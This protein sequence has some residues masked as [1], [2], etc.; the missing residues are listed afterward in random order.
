[1]ST[2]S[3]LLFA[4]LSLLLPGCPFTAEVTHPTLTL[5]HAGSFVDGEALIPE[6]YYLFVEYFIVED[7]TVTTSGARCPAS[8]FAIDFPEYRFVDGRLTGRIRVPLIPDPGERILGLA[9]SGEALQGDNGSG[10][11]SELKHIT[12]LPYTLSLFPMTGRYDDV[13]VHSVHQDGEI[14]AEIGGSTYLMA[15]GEFWMERV[16]QDVMGCHTITIRQFTNYGLLDQY[17]RQK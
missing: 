2:R 11:A 15:P 13:I 14:V 5:R 17:L 8:G 7:G 4:C 3:W 9:G 12:A 1:M 16:E 10:I 6:G